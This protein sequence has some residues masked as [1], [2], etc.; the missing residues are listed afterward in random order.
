MK[1]KQ[2]AIKN[3]IEMS[4]MNKESIVKKESSKLLNWDNQKSVLNEEI[5]ADASSTSDIEEKNLE[6]EKHYNLRW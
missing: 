1:L 5:D 4:N 2:Q 3:L 6:N